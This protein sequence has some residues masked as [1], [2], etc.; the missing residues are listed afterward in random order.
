[1]Q[2]IAFTL[3]LNY[4]TEF[5]QK[6]HFYKVETIY[7]S[8]DNLQPILLL[9]RL[10]F[11]NQKMPK[12]AH[13]MICCFFV[14]CDSKLDMFGLLTRHSKTSLFGSLGSFLTFHL[15]NNQLLE[16]LI[17]RLTDNENNNSLQP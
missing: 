8:T 15:K 7:R 12:N 2:F 11:W 13:G 10:I 4:Q 17:G 9:I 14:L 3:E 5:Y 16:K 6:D 1:M